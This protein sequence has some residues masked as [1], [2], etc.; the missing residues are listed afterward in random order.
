MGAGVDAPASWID[1]VVQRTEGWPVGVYLAA[2]A[3]EAGKP[4][5]DV[6]FGGDDRW[7]SE[8][9][10]SELLSRVEADQADLLMRTSI[11]DRLSGPLCDAV[12]GVTGAARALEDLA[13]QNMLVL[14]LDRHREW[15]RY[16]HLLRDHLNAELRVGARGRDPPA[17]LPGSLL[18]RGQRH[19][20]SCSRPRPG[21]RRCRPGGC[22]DPEAHES[23]LGERTGR[24]GPELDAVARGPSVRQA[25]CGRHGPRLTD[26]RPAR[27]DR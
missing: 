26:L 1:D 10:R 12:A 13:G 11:L 6:A 9:L 7:V 4:I 21:C 18:V 22:P 17:A 20:R 5:G 14:P 27:A 19:A 15:Y 23:R 3:M 16:H 8:Y 2:L 24:H 25:L